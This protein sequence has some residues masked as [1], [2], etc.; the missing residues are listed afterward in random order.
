[1]IVILTPKQREILGLV[2]DGC[3]TG[4]ISETL[5]ISYWSAKKRVRELR[6]KLGAESMWDIPTRAAKLGVEI[7]AAQE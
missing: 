4:C 1:M 5:D 6:E 7:P 3:N 2:A